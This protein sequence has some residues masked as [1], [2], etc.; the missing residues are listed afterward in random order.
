MTCWIAVFSLCVYTF[1]LKD[2]NIN[3]WF[4]ERIIDLKKIVNS[5][6]VFLFRSCIIE[7]FE[8]AKKLNAKEMNNVSEKSETEL[9][10]HQLLEKYVNTS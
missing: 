3:N 7:A 1:T 6:N 8:K 2:Q 9:T 5:A 10:Y 4:I